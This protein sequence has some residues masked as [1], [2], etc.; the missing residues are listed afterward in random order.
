MRTLVAN[1]NE[2]PSRKETSVTMKSFARCYFNTRLVGT[3][4][5]GLLLASGCATLNGTPDTPE[6]TVHRFC[7]LDLEGARLSSSTYP[8]VQ[9]LVTWKGEPGL[10]TMY[11]VSGYTVTGSKT[12][13]ARAE[14]TV[15]YNVLGRFG[16]PWVRQNVDSA[17]DGSTVTFHLVR[18]GDTWKIDGPVAPPH[19]RPGALARVIRSWPQAGTAGDD[20]RLHPTLRLLDSLSKK[21]PS[22]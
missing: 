20:H 10:G 22:K 5:A 12:N 1:H 9:P 14:V 4:L 7:Q 6:A 11:A 13:G 2:M 18:R 3:L 16:V 15:K 8:E 21:A 19:V 17:V